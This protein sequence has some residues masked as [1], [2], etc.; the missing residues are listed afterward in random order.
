MINYSISSWVVRDLPLDEGIAALA[1]A[2]FS[3]VELSADQCPLVQE[4]ERDP[5]ALCRRLEEAGISVPS[6]HCPEPGRFLD[7]TDKTTRLDSIAANLRYLDHMAECGVEQIV[8]H[9]TGAGGGASETPNASR[10]RTLLS[11]QSLAE[12]AGELGLE[13]AVENIGFQQGRPDADM[14]GLLRII[15]GL[16]DHVGLCLDIGHTEI[17]GLDIVAE[18]TTGLQSGKLF[19][20][21]IHDVLP[22][23]R[24]HA[25]PGEGRIDYEPFLTTLS[26]A[27]FTGGRTLEISPPEDNVANRVAQIADVKKRWEASG[28][29][30]EFP[31]P[32][33]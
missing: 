18:L 20:L 10:A 25:I 11:L 31:T 14:A 23:G 21:H 24:D 26:A 7:A 33:G 19:T 2:G 28:G 29:G 5:V 4:W 22:T 9:P 32:C 3:S 17:A 1:S 15:D 6:M 27:G 30:R 13:L 8:I 16:G 12:R